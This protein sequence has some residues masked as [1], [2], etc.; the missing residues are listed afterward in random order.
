MKAGWP[1]SSL[2]RHFLPLENQAQSCSLEIH[3]SHLSSCF[4][5]HPTPPHH[6]PPP[7]YQRPAHLPH[8]NLGIPSS[9]SL[10]GLLHALLTAWG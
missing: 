4:P 8:S 7:Y 2:S 6:T 9:F 10:N 5:P 1:F 3:S